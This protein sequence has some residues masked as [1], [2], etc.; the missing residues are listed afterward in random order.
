MYRYVVILIFALVSLANAAN[1]SMF[2]PNISVI[3][4]GSYVQN[5][6]GGSLH[7]NE[8]EIGLES[9]FDDKFHGNAVIAIGEEGIEV[10]E[11]YFDTLKMPING[12]GLKAGR[13]KWDFGDLNTK[14]PHSDDFAERPLAWLYFMGEEGFNQ[15]GMQVSYLLPV[16]FLFELGGGIFGGNNAQTRYSSLIY[17]KISFDI[18]DSQS[19]LLSAAH[20][21][22][23]GGEEEEETFGFNGF[24]NFATS[25]RA[26]G[27]EDR[28]LFNISFKYVINFS[29]SRITFQSELFSENDTVLDSQGY[30]A[31]I[32]YRYNRKIG[33]GVSLSQV[34][35]NNFSA[36]NVYA[37]SYAA[38]ADYAN[39]EFSR[40]RLQFTSE[41][42]EETGQ[43]NN[44]II[45]NYNFAMG[46][47]GAHAY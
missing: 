10:E 34:R 14:H 47:H 20:L 38:M 36:N 19:F 46:A 15:D 41:K 42:N 37:T 22:Q 23:S 25:T 40:F 1:Q 18:T 32:V 29:L 13:A 8:T 17:T 24:D 35:D 26:L 27:E 28:E 3:F 4:D 44:S 45:L 11:A 5:E 9:N 31:N 7:L 30:Y 12:L 2:N 16:P 6:E 43:T 39:S 33:V 21:I